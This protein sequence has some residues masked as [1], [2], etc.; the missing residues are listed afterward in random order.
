MI[1]NSRRMTDFTWWRW[2]TP[3]IWTPKAGLGVGS[4]RTSQFPV[5]SGGGSEPP[6]LPPW[7]E[8][9]LNAGTRAKA[10]SLR[11][12]NKNTRNP[13]KFKYLSFTDAPPPPSQS[14]KSSFPALTPP[15]A[16]ASAPE[17][18]LSGNVFLCVCVRVLDDPPPT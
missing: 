13:G 1:L 5:N 12:A 7:S 8:A 10:S 4:G 6:C 18:R 14:S 15:C 9:S 16:P 17:A 3:G 11:L 2:Q